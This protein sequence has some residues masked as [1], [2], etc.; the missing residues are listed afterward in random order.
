[1][2][3]KMHTVFILV[4]SLIVSLGI[5]ASCNSKDQQ[6]MLRQEREYTE[7]VR[8]ARAPSM[9]GDGLA[10]SKMDGMPAGIEHDRE[11]Y[12]KRTENGFFDA[13]RIPLS[14]FSIDVDTASWANIRRFLQS[15]RLP[16][17]D[18]VRLEECVNYFPYAYEGP[19]DGRPFAVHAEVADCPWAEGRQLVRIGVQGKHISLENLPPANLVFLLDVSGSMFSENK[20][21]LVKNALSM[22]TRKLRPQDRVSIVVYAG[23]AGLVLPPTKGSDKETI[24]GA[25]DRLQAGG[26]TAGGAGIKLAYKVAEENFDRNGNNRVILCTDGDF[27]VGASSDGEMVRL[28][29]EKRATGVYLTILGFGMGNYQ[30]AKIQKMADAGNGNYS[31]IDSAMEARKVLINQMGGTLL[32][33]AK[34]VKIQVEFNPAYVG[35]YRLLGYEKRMLRAEDFRDDKKDAGELG[36][37]H[38]V[39]AIYE[40]VPKGGANPSGYV[41]PLRYATNAV[42]TGVLNNELVTVKLRYK[43]PG[44]DTSTGFSIPVRTGST[45]IDKASQEM[46]F[47]VSVAEAALLL[48]GS[49]FKGKADWN[50]LI[51][52]AKS[53]LGRDEEGYRAEFIRL[54]KLAAGMQ[55]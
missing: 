51:D 45:R 23:A 19:S 15:G 28:I 12:E 14:T 7:A 26:S 10:K 54:A 34:D 35:S 55:D 18:A 27:N 29:E 31:Y 32:T 46:R 48:Y 2:T 39:T 20:L 22:L 24:L 16:P 4:S 6:A 41:E 13:A 11:Q 50:T 49:E 1:M 40:I 33:I 52:R 44:N 5:F 8:H 53:S 47:A 30:D 43:L 37:G 17:K 42:S 9:N 36:A 38:S 25:L 3:H 21:P